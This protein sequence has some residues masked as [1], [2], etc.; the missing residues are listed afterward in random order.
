MKTKHLTIMF[1]DI[2]GFTS[3]TSKSSRDQLEKML[4]THEK[5]ILPVFRDFRGRIIKT[6][7]DAFMVSFYSPTDAVLCGMKIQDV[8]NK[9]NE[10]VPE[11]DRLEVRVAINSGEVTIKDNDVF[12]EAVNIAARLEGIADAGDIYFTEAVYLAMN[13]SEIPTAEIGYREFKGI[14]ENI[15]IY[16]VLTGK[17]RGFILGRRDKLLTRENLYKK[18]FRKIIKYGAIALAIIFLLSFVSNIL[19]SN[20]KQLI[21]DELLVKDGGKFLDT[22]I[23]D[24]SVKENDLKLKIDEILLA[25]EEGDSER[26]L[27]GINQIVE[28][29][30]EI[31]NPPEMEEVIINLQTI[32]DKKFVDNY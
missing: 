12:G 15:K 8:L 14:P 32:Y 3:R 16:R 6:I 25:I 2:K 13:K 1:T 18:R 29:S 27:I 31:G 20:K 5:L 4:E 11:E 26:A 19:D 9:H 10:D 28:Y 17:K 7:G 22:P 23:D 24:I 21:Q 30:N